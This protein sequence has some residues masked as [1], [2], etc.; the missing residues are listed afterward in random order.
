MKICI[1]A[2]GNDLNATTDTAFGRALWFILVD[3]E[4]DAV[5]AIKNTSID[6]QHGAGIAAAQ[7]MADNKVDAVLTGR[8]GPK[9]QIALTAAEVKMY[10]GLSRS[11]V[12]EALQ[13]FRKGT[14]SETTTN[15]GAATV[16]PGQARFHG[17]G[18]NRCGK[19]QGKG[20]GRGQDKGKGLARRNSE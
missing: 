19:G 6:V 9:A 1:T 2:A 15:P 13:Q 10:E 5:E 12:A 16:G 4:S 8:L 7:L 20:Q 18:G 11:T 3:T 14:Y 17:T